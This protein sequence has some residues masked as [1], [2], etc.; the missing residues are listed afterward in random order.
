MLIY[1][2]QDESKKYERLV[3]ITSD[4]YKVSKKKTKG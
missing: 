4:C 3:A 1:G 2:M